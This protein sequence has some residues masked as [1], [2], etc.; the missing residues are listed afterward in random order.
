MKKRLCI[1]LALI[2]LVS[3]LAGC[4]SSAAPAS[5]GENSAPAA[6]S[7]G[8]PAKTIKY[9]SM[10]TE[11]EPQAIWLA[12]IFAAFEAETGIHVEATWVGRDVLTSMIT[13][14]G[15]DNCPDLIDQDVCELTGALL[16]EDEQLLIPI[17]DVL[18]GPGPDGEPTLMSV[19]NKD[20]LDMYKF[21]DKYYF[22]PYNFITSGFFYD[23]TLWE[24]V[25]A[26]VP[27]TWD[28]FLAVSKTFADAGVPLCAQDNENMYNLYWL[29]WAVERQ[30]GPGALLAACTDTSGETWKQPGYLKAAEMVYQASQAGE[31]V[32][33][34]NY[35]GS[36][37][38]ASQSDFA[39]GNEGC[40]LNGSWI[41]VE[42]MNMTDE[43]FN[44][45]YFPFPSVDGGYAG[46]EQME[47][48]IIGMSIPTNAKNPDLAKQLMVFMSKK[49]LAQ[50]LSDDALCMH[51]RT[52]VTLPAVL[53]DIQPYL[54]NAKIWNPIYDYVAAKAPQYT[55]D[56]LYHN[57][58]SLLHGELTAEEFI[59]SI[60]ADSVAFYNK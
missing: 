45:G 51:C 26:E 1:L 35:A 19:F 27:T 55:A 4:G 44:W 54:D 39:L 25:G 46:T 10:W 3:M 30:L 38:P 21:Q 2:M 28:E 33:E 14:L 36:L 50:K 42:L 37:W 6:S 9:A 49:D 48:Y 47:G 41:P 29:Y 60:V 22:L 17:E 32:F 40:I 34:P 43:S 56:V 18:N 11:S 59:N 15:S 52:D 57:T 16:K 5:T 23:K 53:A 8:D 13:Q 58:N 7:A 12:E 20:I 24:K 31:N